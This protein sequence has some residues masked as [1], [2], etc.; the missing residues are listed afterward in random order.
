[1]VGESVIDIMS[2]MTL[3]KKDGVDYH[4]YNYLAMAGTQK[5]EAIEYVL[6]NNRQIK[7]IYLGMDND[8][9][10]LKAAKQLEESLSGRNIVLKRDMPDKSGYDGMICFV[11]QPVGNNRK[12]LS[13]WRML[14]SIKKV[15]MI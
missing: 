5:Q 12:P 1:M 2:K 9:G 4:D 3:L 6:D 10:G 7:E 14:S 8:A 11:L 13:I 15:C